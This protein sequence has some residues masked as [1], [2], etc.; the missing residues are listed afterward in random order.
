[1]RTSTSFES[2]FDFN[3]NC[4]QERNG[5]IGFIAIAYSPSRSDLYVA[6][7]F[8]ATTSFASPE[9]SFLGV[10]GRLRC[11]QLQRDRT[12]PGRSKVRH[13]MDPKF[14]RK[15]PQPESKKTAQH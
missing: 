12:P 5:C 4:N 15:F 8:E 9:T 1:M 13:S 11:H 10:Y 3:K 7:D 6:P 2:S 14:L